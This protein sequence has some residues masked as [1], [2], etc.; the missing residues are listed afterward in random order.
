MKLLELPP[1]KINTKS[2]E[3][4]QYILKFVIFFSKMLLKVHELIVTSLTGTRG[5]ACKA[6]DVS[7]QHEVDYSL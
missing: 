4:L 3:F 5:R 7:L 1:L 6:R 2:Q